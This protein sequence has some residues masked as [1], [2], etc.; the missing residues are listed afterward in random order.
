MSGPEHYAYA[1]QLLQDAMEW[2]A[3]DHEQ[4]ALIA[5]AQVHATL[6]LVAATAQPQR[7]AWY[8][9]KNTEDSRLWVKATAPTTERTS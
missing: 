4:A 2:T 9:T 8:G 5:E 1:E 3:Q 7:D 6:A